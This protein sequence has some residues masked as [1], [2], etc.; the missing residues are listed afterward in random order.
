MVFAGHSEDGWRRDV[1]GVLVETPVAEPAPPS[2]NLVL[3]WPAAAKIMIRSAGTRRLR[4]ALAPEHS[5]GLTP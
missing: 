3:N 4:T 1:Q 5:S 2:V